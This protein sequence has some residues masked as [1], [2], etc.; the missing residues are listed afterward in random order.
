MK[1]YVERTKENLELDFTGSVQELLDKL[2]ILSETALV[3]RDGN[4]ITEDE[5]ISNED[6]IK[7]L[8]VIS[9]G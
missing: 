1:L 5:E 7:L 6:S 8:S 4:I 3:A 2:N 9:G